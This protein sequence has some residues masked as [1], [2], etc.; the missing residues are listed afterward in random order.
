M[1]TYVHYL[2]RKLGRAGRRDGARRRLPAGASVTSATRDLRR[3]SLRLGLQT[4]LLVVGV[5]V[6]VGALLF[7]VYERSADQAAA[8]RCATRPRTSTRPDEAPPGVHVVVVTPSGRTQSAGMPAGFPTR[9]R[10]PRCAATAGSGRRRCRSAVES[11][12]CARPRSGRGS[13]RPCWTATRSTSSAAGSSPRCS[14]PAASASCSPRSSR[15]SWPA[16]R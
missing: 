1:D 11:T 4:G 9:T 14:S 2:R 6:V 16:A 10:S 5:L 15:P 8:E 12:P 3:T 13:P 7:V